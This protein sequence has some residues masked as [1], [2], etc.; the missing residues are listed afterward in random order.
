[1][2]LHLSK[3]VSRPGLEP[4]TLGFNCQSFTILSYMDDTPITTI[5]ADMNRL[6]MTSGLLFGTAR[7]NKE[8]VN[9]LQQTIDE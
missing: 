7:Q 4:R 2:F 8:Q 1:M 5:V 3:N 6:V 9:E